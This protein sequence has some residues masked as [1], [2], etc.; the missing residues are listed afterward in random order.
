MFIVD[1]ISIKIIGI[2]ASF[3][4]I[5]STLIQSVSSLI[6]HT[7]NLEF[8]QVLKPIVKRKKTIIVKISISLD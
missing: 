4:I 1:S 6:I 3:I 7:F 8:L 2:F 5:L